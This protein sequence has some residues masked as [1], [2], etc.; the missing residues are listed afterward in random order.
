MLQDW[1]L[2]LENIGS[3]SVCACSSGGW[4]AFCVACGALHI[5]CCHFSLDVP[6]PLHVENLLVLQLLF[7]V[8]EP[9]FC[10]CCVK[11]NLKLQLSSVFLDRNSSCTALTSTAA[12]WNWLLKERFQECHTHTSR[13]VLLSALCSRVIVVLS[14]LIDVL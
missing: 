12:T 8:L 10:Y 3:A 5:F 4:F 14:L 11:T 7:S 13:F 1:L 2:Y 6:L 9:L